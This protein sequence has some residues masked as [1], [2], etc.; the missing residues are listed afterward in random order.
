MSVRHECSEPL[1]R[2]LSDSPTSTHRVA[3]GRT[4][5]VAIFGENLLADDLA[6]VS[7][8]RATGLI[9]TL[10]GHRDLV[11]QFAGA[12]YTTVQ[13]TKPTWRRRP[14][15]LDHIFYNSPLRCVA[16]R[17]CPTSASDHHV[18]EADFEFI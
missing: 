10:S 1:S 12:G 16:H 13:E 7:M 3:E 8:L 18:L 14:Y 5:W 9:V 4:E 6:L 17:V 15:V 2:H 11:D